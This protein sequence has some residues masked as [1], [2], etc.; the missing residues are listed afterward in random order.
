MPRTPENVDGRVKGYVGRLV[1]T[2]L[3]E[4]GAPNNSQ[5]KPKKKRDRKKDQNPKK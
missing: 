3:K 1:D 5:P 2:T 4:L